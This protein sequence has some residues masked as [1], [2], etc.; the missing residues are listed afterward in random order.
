[1]TSSG[2]ENWPPIGLRLNQTAR[3][4]AQGFERAMTE[5]GGSPTTW[6]VLL[7]VRSQEWDTQSLIADA[8]GIS[9]ATLTHHLNALEAEGL[10]RRWRE[11]E[12]RRVQH[13]ELT[14]EGTAMFERLRGAAVAY[15]KRLR[16]LLG[17]DGATQLAE[18]LDRLAPGLKAPAMGVPDES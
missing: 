17:E 12:N 18:L 4:V 13:V 7:L 2:P 15:D 3:I 16:S 1:M 10:V 8:M 5:A 9:G 6:Q 11:H 14:A